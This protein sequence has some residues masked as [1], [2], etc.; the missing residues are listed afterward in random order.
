M[1]I[2]SS[3]LGAGNELKQRSMLGAGDTVADGTRETGGGF[4][5]PLLARV[6]AIIGASGITGA[7]GQLGDIS[8]IHIRDPLS[9]PGIIEH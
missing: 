3:L 9:D 1:S 5:S 8:G 4:L 7:T 2:V 6:A